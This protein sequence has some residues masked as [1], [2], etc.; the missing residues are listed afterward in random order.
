MQPVDQIGSLLKGTDTS[1]LVDAVT[2]LGGMP[3]K[4]DEW[5]ID[6]AAVRMELLKEHHIEIGAGLGP[7]AGQIWRIG[8]MG[9]TAR[10]DNVCRLLDTLKRML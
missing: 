3:V 10:P 1:F 6:E 5:G 7:L 2:S 8:L 4:V 9:H